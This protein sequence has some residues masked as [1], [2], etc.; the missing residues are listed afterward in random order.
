[1]AGRIVRSRG[2]CEYPDC[3]R[4]DVVWAH[5]IRRRYGATRCIEDGAWALCPTHHD[6]VDNWPDEHLK[7]VRATIGEDR[8]WELKR[9]ANAGLPFTSALFWAGEVARLKDRCRELGLSATRK[10]DV[11]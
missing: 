6:L 10:K 11:A 1:L 2:R 4:C 8:Y 5:I 9:I 3:D 7:V